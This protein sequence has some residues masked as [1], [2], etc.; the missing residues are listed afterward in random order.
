M[1]L[2]APIYIVES[3][4]CLR[5]HLPLFKAR[6]APPL[7]VTR[8]FAHDVVYQKMKPVHSLLV[9]PSL[10]QVSHPPFHILIEIP[11]LIDTPKMT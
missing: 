3:M 11:Q 5:H 8:I 9:H 10:S 2:Q 1:G 7:F 6:K 4:R